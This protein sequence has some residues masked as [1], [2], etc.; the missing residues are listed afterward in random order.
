M[1]LVAEPRS[2][3]E[4]IPV[5][6]S[7]TEAEAAQAE[8]VFAIFTSVTII[9]QLVFYVIFATEIAVHVRLSV[10]DWRRRCQTRCLL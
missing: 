4:P 9:V 2:P 3:A 5:P 7:F 8:I 6:A 10:K 1:A